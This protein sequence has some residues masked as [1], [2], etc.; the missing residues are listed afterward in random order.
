[1]TGKPRTRSV[2]LVGGPM[3]GW[4]TDLPA[5]TDEFRLGKFWTYEYAGKDGQQ[6][7]FA[8]RDSGRG[9]RRFV[10]AFIAAHGKHPLVAAVRG[11]PT[12]GRTDRRGQGAR[13]RAAKRAS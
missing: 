7:L 8:L 11:T 4:L 10:R 2:K 1:M 12:R 3:D 6:V 5:G 13:R 9:M